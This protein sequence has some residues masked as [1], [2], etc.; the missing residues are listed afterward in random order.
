MMEIFYKGKR[1]FLRCNCTHSWHADG[2]QYG[3]TEYPDIQPSKHRC[4]VCEMY[5]WYIPGLNQE[6]L[7]FTDERKED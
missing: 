2:E 1:F 7:E 6:D 3:G 5:A 4:P